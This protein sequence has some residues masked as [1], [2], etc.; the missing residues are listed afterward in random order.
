MSPL[1]LSFSD[2]GPRKFKTL[3]GS[4]NKMRVKKSKK[5]PNKQTKKQTKNNFLVTEKLKSSR[6]N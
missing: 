2:S 6:M 1:S 4:L 5:K 3:T